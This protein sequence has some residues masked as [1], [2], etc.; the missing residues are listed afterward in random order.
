MEV[1]SPEGKVRM[2]KQPW[3]VLAFQIAG[4]DGLK[5]LHAEG[6]AEERNTAPAENLMIRLEVPARKVL[7]P[8]LI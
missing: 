7:E 1:R 5:L 2:L 8:C 6:K 3:S 4:D